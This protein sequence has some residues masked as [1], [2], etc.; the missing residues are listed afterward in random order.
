ME[1]LFE[2]IKV[3]V[4]IIDLGKLSPNTPE[5]KRFSE[6]VVEVQNEINAIKIKM[7]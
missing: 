3:S 1:I 4:N 6:T 2:F 5:F 7:I